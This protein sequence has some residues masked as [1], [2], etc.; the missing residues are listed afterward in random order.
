[1]VP[2]HVCKIIVNTPAPATK[3]THKQ[4]QQ[5]PACQLVPI[6]AKM[7]WPTSE[8]TWRNS[9]PQKESCQCS[10]QQSPTPISAKTYKR[11]QFGNLPKLRQPL[12][13]QRCSITIFRYVSSYRVWIKLHV[14]TIILFAQN[15]WRADFAATI[16]Q[17][18][19]VWHCLTSSI[20]TQVQNACRGKNKVCK[21]IIPQIRIYWDSLKCTV[22]IY[23]YTYNTKIIQKWEPGISRFPIYFK[24]WLSHSYKISERKSQQ[25]KTNWDETWTLVIQLSIFLPRTFLVNSVLFF[26]VKGIDLSIIH[27]QLQ[28]TASGADEKI[29]VR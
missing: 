5:F 7:R 13:K 26:L 11:S 20:E 3:I 21:Q 19:D 16:W 22:N 1:M 23:I 10:P 6:F 8:L 28:D 29:K 18:A 14:H 12:H 15:S 4:T 2:T 17:R 25:P 24:W 27:L 9:H